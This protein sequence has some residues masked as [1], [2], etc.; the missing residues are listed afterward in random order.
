MPTRLI[1]ASFGIIGFVAAL[2]TGLF[3]DNPI[4]IVLG[5]AIGAMIFCYV[6]GYILGWAGQAAVEEHIRAYK[7]SHP[8]PQPPVV[9][10]E[11]SE[12]VIDESDLSAQ[13]LRE[14]PQQTEGSASVEADAPSPK[15]DSTPT[16][17]A[18]HADREAAA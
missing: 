2:T 18:E 1:A 7:K 6:V 10:P 16:A 12:D 11:D 15:Q 5:R 3:A 14:E 17:E 4:L 8:I 9:S 13:H